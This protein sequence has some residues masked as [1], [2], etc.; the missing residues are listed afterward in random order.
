M[1]GLPRNASV[2]VYCAGKR[3]PDLNVGAAAA[4]EVGRLLRALHGR[5]F[6]AGDRLKLTVTAPRHGA[7]RILVGIRDNHQPTARLVKH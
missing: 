7:E 2:A 6:R 1:R 3:C 5:V 4:G